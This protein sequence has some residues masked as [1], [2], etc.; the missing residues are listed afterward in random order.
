M[1]W[2]VLSFPFF[3]SDQ[4][5]QPDREIIRQSLVANGAFSQERAGT[6]TTHVL[7]P[8]LSN[9]CIKA[10]A[11]RSA[12]D[13]SSPALAIKGFVVAMLEYARADI[14]FA[15]YTHWLANYSPACGER[16]HLRWLCSSFKTKGNC[17]FRCF[18]YW[19]GGGYFSGIREQLRL[20]FVSLPLCVFI[21][22]PST[23]PC[24]F[25]CHLARVFLG[26]DLHT[27]V[28]L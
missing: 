3:Q 2:G 24:Y 21:P 25:L 26:L 13:K 8:L 10:Q 22:P 15:D 19:R 12:L 14:I 7:Q 27:A 5:L 9:H 11:K 28:H 17:S 6:Q 4:T 1:G 23:P 20:L 18:P 16:S